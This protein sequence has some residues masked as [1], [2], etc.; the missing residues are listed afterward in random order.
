M[1]SDELAHKGGDGEGYKWSQTPE[2]VEVLVPLPEGA[3]GKD[4]SVKFSKRKL[5]IA[6]KNGLSLTLDPLYGDIRTD[7]SSWTV[8]KGELVITMEKAKET[9]VWP[10]LS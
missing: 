2:D 6:V 1:T 4:C 3:K 7:D 9:E 8:S 10:T 5:I